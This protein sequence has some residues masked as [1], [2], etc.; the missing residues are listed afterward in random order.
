MP[1]PWSVLRAPG[2]YR[3]TPNDDPLHLYRDVTI[4]IDPER[5]LHS[6]QPSL[7]ALL[8]SHLEVGP[9]S[10]VLHIGCGAGYFTAV[11]AELVGASGRVTAFEV[12]GAL[13][14][15]AR[16]ALERWQQIDVVTADGTVGDLPLAGAILVHAGVT[17]PPE[18]WLDRLTARGRLVFP[19]TDAQGR[20]G[21]VRVTG[22]DPP[23]EALEARFVLYGGAFPCA[24]S[25]SDEAA[26]RLAR[27]YEGGGWEDV[28]ALRRDQ[29]SEDKSCWFHLAGFCLST[30]RAADGF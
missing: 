14:E 4:A 13:A 30:S 2:G 11:L 17:R 8:M 28:R 18:A 19:L 15:R 10:R 22:S 9:G 1:G 23:A 29:H 26:E 27:A 12:D 6:G 7:I 20:G 5:A 3:S 24:G 21:C 25:R 16:A